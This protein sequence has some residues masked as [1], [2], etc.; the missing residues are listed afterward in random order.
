MNMTKS[1]AGLCLSAVSLLLPAVAFGDEI[2]CTGT[3]RGSFDNVNVPPGRNCTLI[4][5]RVQGSIYVRGNATLNVYRTSI[6]GNIQSEGARYVRLHGSGVNLDGSVQI[7]YATAASSI[8]AGTWIG[9][10]VQ[11]EE[12]TGSLSISGARV[13]Q[14]VQI[15]NN[16]G[17]ASVFNNTINGNLQ[18][19]ESDPP[20]TGGGNAV[21]G[22]KEDQCASF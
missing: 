15:F 19:K 10:S 22:N 6:K 12:N 8:A 20:P 11:Y 7:K 18:C 14:D 4:D 17:G 2:N 16:W 13:G 3:L 5:S 1:F 9:G 21:G